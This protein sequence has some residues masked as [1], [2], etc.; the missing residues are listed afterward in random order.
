MFK[1]YK[2]GSC[3]VSEAEIAAFLIK[4]VAKTLNVL[5]SVPYKNMLEFVGNTRSIGVNITRII[6]RS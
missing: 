5:A 4:A 6:W 3:L 2:I 1:M